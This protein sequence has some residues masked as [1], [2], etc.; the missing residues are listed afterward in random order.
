MNRLIILVLTSVALA[1][2]GSSTR[3]SDSTSTFVPQSA[4]AEGMWNGTTNNGATVTGFVLDDG[5]Y[6]AVYTDPYGSSITGIVLGNGSSTNGTYSTTNAKD[7]YFGSSPNVTNATVS[8]SYVPMQTFSGSVSYS[9]GTSATFSTSYDTRYDQTPSLTTLA[10]TY[11][12]SIVGG[13]TNTV[14]NYDSAL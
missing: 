13:S 9:N 8:G 5:A 1:G 2:C 4:S 12:G 7:F 14:V 3:E 11:S 6:Y 10:G